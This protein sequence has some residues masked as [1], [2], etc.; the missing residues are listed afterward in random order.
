MRVATWNVWWRFGDWRPRQAVIFDELRSVGADVIALQE[1]WPAQVDELAQALDMASVFSGGAPSGHPRGEF[2]NAILSRWPILSTAEQTLPAKDGP[3]IRRVLHA[4]VDAPLGPVDVF[5]THLS[6]RFD[7]SAT[8]V[9]QLQVVSEFIERQRRSDDAGHP[10]ILLGDLNAVPDSDELRR[11]TGR[12]QPYLDG[13]VWSDAWELVGE[14]DG[15][16]WDDAN[17]HVV[18]SAW[19]QRRIDYV[20]V[21]WPRPRPLG[22]PLRAERFGTPRGSGPPGS[23]HWGVVVDLGESSPT[24]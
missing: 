11:L 22:N 23:D 13:T 8:R 3:D 12:S 18:D 24:S 10:P 7:E 1:T 17:E 5:T 20:L 6:H 21:A 2:G 4:R 9:R 15:I 16:T 19:P 14:G